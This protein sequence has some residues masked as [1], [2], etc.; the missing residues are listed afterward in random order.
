M[1]YIQIYIYIY[2]SGSLTSLRVQ[3]TSHANARLQLPVLCQLRRNKDTMIVFPLC[4]YFVILFILC[5]CENKLVCFNNKERLLKDEWGDKVN[6]DK[7]D[8]VVKR[9][10]NIRKDSATYFAPLFLAT[11]LKRIL[12]KRFFR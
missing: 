2:T 8:L 1:I 5:F 12:Q 4:V 10:S 7:S 3:L 11:R 6:R 9:C